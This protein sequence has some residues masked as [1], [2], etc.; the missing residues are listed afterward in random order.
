M[1]LRCTNRGLLLCISNRPA[2]RV[3][4]IFLQGAKCNSLVFRST[5]LEFGSISIRGVQKKTTKIGFVCSCPNFL[6]Q[7]KR[8]GEWGI[9]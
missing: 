5:T 9:L 4:D 3:N 6:H 8:S 7:T 2:A 1:N